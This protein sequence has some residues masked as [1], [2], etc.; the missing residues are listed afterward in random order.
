MSLG[1]NESQEMDRAQDFLPLAIRDYLMI[2]IL[3]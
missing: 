2:I 1:A 3:P